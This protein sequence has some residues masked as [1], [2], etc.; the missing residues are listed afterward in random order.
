M[1]LTTRSGT[2]SKLG[3]QKKGAGDVMRKQ[4]K[5]QGNEGRV[6]RD[7]GGSVMRERK[8]WG[9]RWEVGWQLVGGVQQD[10][11]QQEILYERP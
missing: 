3:A 6:R 1:A 8:S 11:H 5:E 9:E 7:D 4:K 10:I 2:T